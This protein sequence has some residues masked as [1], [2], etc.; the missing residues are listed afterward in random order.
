[1]PNPTIAQYLLG[2][3]NDTSTKPT[4]TWGGSIDNS[5]SGTG[6]YGTA[7]TIK[8]AIAGSDAAT[9]NSSGLRLIGSLG[10]GNSAAA[11][12]PG[13]VVKKIEVFDATGVSLGFI[14]VYDAIS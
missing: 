13:T 8:L 3:I 4:I 12:T 7:S 2:A 5:S 11:T 10:V 1:M 6:I 14:A 9:I